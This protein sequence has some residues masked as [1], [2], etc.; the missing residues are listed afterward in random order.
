MRVSRRR[1]RLGV[2][3]AL[4]LPL[5]AGVSTTIGQQDLAGLLAHQ[6]GVTE[7][8]RVVLLGGPLRALKTA[9]FAWPS[10]GQGPLGSPIT[11]PPN[12]EL[13]ISVNRSA[14]AD[15][16]PLAVKIP[17][18][19]PGETLAGPASEAAAAGDAGTAT[20]PTDTDENLVASFDGGDPTG[21]PS[22]F[23][24][25]ADDADAPE[26]ELVE[27]D[28]TQSV[29]TLPAG[30]AALTLEESVA[31]A[32]PADGAGLKPIYNEAAFIFGADPSAL[33]PQPFFHAE[34]GGTTVAAKGEV[35]GEGAE[36]SS[37]AERLGLDGKR[38]ARAQK[39]LAEAVYFE[40]R[41]EP[42]RGQVGV[43]QVVVNRVF[44]GYYP[45]DVCRAVY[46]NANRKL[47]C[48]FTFACDNVRD[49]VTEPELWKQ[50]QRI[51]G[52][53][54]DGRIWDDKVGKATHYHASYVRPR[55]V[56]EMR[57]LDRIG[58]HTFYRPRRWSS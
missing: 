9:T 11:E 33:P 3:T 20:D 34:A 47:G 55:W 48:Q 5:T 21:D 4:L 54:L 18:G 40:S 26:Q 58:E 32:A 31:L 24:D 56:R 23:E 6:P 35:T 28:G 29:G 13:G 39:C 2:F 51:A 25:G 44:S 42:Y 27:S 7:R 17:A 30:E 46:Q 57:K 12:V 8:A 53:M 36:P 19:P 43:A 41:G 14:K 15:R 1:R 22:E 45:A 37:P 49:V 38:L 10:A 50:A 16:L 52:D